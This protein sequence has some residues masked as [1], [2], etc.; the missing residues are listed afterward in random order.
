AV[1]PDMEYVV[2]AESARA[3]RSFLVAADRLDELARVLA[4]SA[5]G[6]T[7]PTQL[8]ILGRV[9]GAQLA[10]AL[11]AHPLSAALPPVP[12]LI[13]SQQGEGGVQVRTSRVICGSHVTND[14]GSGI[15]HTAPGHGHDDFAVCQAVNVHAAAVPHGGA[16]AAAQ[17]LLPVLCPVDEAGKYDAS[18]GAALHGLPV[19]KEG[20]E[21]LLTLLR[22]SG[23]LLL[24]EEYTHRYPYDWRSKKPIIIRATKQWFVNVHR[25]MD[26]CR[27]ALADVTM[28]P[29]A[30]RNRLTAML[31]TRTEWCISRQR[32]WGV[33]IPALYNKRTGEALMTPESVAHIADAIGR[34]GSNIWWEWE[35]SKLLPPSITSGCD[36]AALDAEW[37]KGADTLDVWFDSGASWAAAWAGKPSADSA[38]ACASAASASFDLGRRSDM[39]LEGSDQHRGWFQSSLITGAAAVGAAPYRAVLTHGFV[40]DEQMRKMSKSLGNVIAPS[41]II[42]GRGGS[43]A[44]PATPSA[45]AASSSSS[46]N[47]KS[48][49]K[50]SGRGTAAGSSAFSVGQGVDVAR[51]WVAA[52]DYSKDVVVGPSVLSTISEHVR[53]IRNTSR[54]ILGNIADYQLLTASASSADA[55]PHADAVAAMWSAPHV[56]LLRQPAALGPLERGILD[57]VA[58]FSAEVS[59]GYDAYAFMR[60]VNAVNAFVSVDLSSQYFDFCKDRLYAG[61]APTPTQAVLWESLRALVSA[62]API[63]PFT[64]EDVYQHSANLAGIQCAEGKD[65]YVDSTIFDAVL[66][67]PLAAWRSTASKMV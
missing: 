39:V 1:H 65:V 19:L 49:G 31:G 21:A 18:L 55:A 51:Y 13:Q 25:L 28:V 37:V 52:S 32:S 20:N 10:G 42:N 48:S 22:Q 16:S 27:D 7:P 54:F 33:P 36:A 43:A 41:D 29:A 66:P 67:Q 64:A 40:L 2:A 60:V 26:T 46:A 44:V 12:E 50:G 8:S 15:V 62:V 4:P 34:H 5:A 14:S 11:F 6:A 57:R 47:T 24:A 58:A 61:L 59:S 38:S 3:D 23:Q 30:S 17:P 45:H 9:V 63:L 35:A 53:K 56:P